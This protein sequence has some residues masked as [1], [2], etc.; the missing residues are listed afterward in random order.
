MISVSLTHEEFYAL[1]IVLRRRISARWTRRLR[2]A[3]KHSAFMIAL[4]TD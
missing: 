3:K 2:A 1:P 4:D